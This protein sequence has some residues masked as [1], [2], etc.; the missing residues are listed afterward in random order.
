M[1]D[2]RRVAERACQLARSGAC[3][4]FDDLLACLAAEGLDPDDLDQGL[5]MR[6]MLKGLMRQSRVRPP[7]PSNPIAERQTRRPPGLARPSQA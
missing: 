4:T 6:R 7:P 2:S 3:Q 1:R 5:N